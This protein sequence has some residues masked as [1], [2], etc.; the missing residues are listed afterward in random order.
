MK[1]NFPHAEMEG[2]ETEHDK[3][4]GDLFN[5]LMDHV[6]T[7]GKFQSR[8]NYLY[9]MALVVLVAMPALNIIL[10]LTSPDHWCHVPG[11]N[12][13]NLTSPEWKELTIPR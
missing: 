2:A 4:D 7:E 6:G 3:A 9:N 13:T 12:T 5:D 10:A 11:R 8:F 1:G